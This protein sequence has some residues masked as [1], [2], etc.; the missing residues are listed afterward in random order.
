MTTEKMTQAMETAGA[1]SQ[2]AVYGDLDLGSYLGTA[3]QVSIR[4][5]TELYAASD[6]LG[7][8]GT[9][10]SATDIHSVGDATNAGAITNLVTT[11]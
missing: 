1:G 6:Q 9:L 3:R 11:A 7:V 4:T 8:I 10:R 2:I 5:L